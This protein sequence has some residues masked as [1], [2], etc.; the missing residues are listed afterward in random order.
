MQRTL[1]AIYWMATSTVI[2]VCYLGRFAAHIKANPLIMSSAVVRC[3]NT[4]K[5]ALRVIFKALP[6][7]SGEFPVLPKRHAIGTLIGTIYRH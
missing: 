6:S 5:I 2:V 7:R 1:K 4:K 3:H